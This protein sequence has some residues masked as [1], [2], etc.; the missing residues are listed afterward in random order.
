MKTAL[1]SLFPLLACN[2]KGSVVIDVED[3]AEDTA[4]EEGNPGD[5]DIEDTDTEDT[6]PEEET[7][8]TDNAN[9]DIYPNYWSGTRTVN[10][11]GCTETIVEEGVEISFDIPAEWMELCSCDEIYYVEVV[12]GSACG[13]SVQ[14]QFY[15]AVKYNGFEMDIWYYQNP[16]ETSPY[17]PLPLA[18]ARIDE[19]G[20]TWN[21]RYSPDGSGDEIRIEGTVDFSQ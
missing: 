3:I 19:D 20:E 14:F 12:G 1:I 13:L 2:S 7:P 21:Y 9:P 11:Q 16:E 10:Y 6:D 4:T 15:R 5:T 8:P 18:K 17:E